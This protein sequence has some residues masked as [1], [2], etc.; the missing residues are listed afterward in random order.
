MER[1][2]LRLKQG[3]SGG[4]LKI[5]A[6]GTCEWK[7]QSRDF[8]LLTCSGCALLTQSSFSLLPKGKSRPWVTW[9]LYNLGGPL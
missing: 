4:L 9:H 1:E 8:T 7:G 5:M 3:S 6:F 2:L